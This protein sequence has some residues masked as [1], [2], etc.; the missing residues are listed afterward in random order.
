MTKTV[1]AVMMTV[2][3]M[4]TPAHA[5]SIDTGSLFPTVFYPEPAPEPVTRDVAQPGG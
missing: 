2:A 4:M 5:M 1:F 3:M